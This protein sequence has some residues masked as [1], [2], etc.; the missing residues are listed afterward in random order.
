MIGSEIV[1]SK[2]LTT[3][4]S[5]P[6]GKDGKDCLADSKPAIILG[7]QIVD[8]FCDTYK[9]A[10][11]YLQEYNP[12]DAKGIDWVQ[13]VPFILAMFTQ[14]TV[15]EDAYAQGF[16]KAFGID[17]KKV[18]T[19]RA[20]RTLTVGNIIQVCLMPEGKVPTS[21]EC[22]RLDR[23]LWMTEKQLNNVPSFPLSLIDYFACLYEQH[24]EGDKASALRRQF[25][26]LAK[27]S[28]LSK[29][30]HPERSDLKDCVRLE[31][32]YELMK[33]L[34]SL[35]FVKPSWG[36]ERAVSILDY[37]KQHSLRR[38]AW[39]QDLLKQVKKIG[40]F[41][42]LAKLPCGTDCGLI[43]I[44]G[45]QKNVR[46][47]SLDFAKKLVSAYRASL[48]KQSAAEPSAE[49]VL[50]DLQMWLQDLEKIEPKVP[51]EKVRRK[52]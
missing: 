17:A 27:I 13:N 5:L 4:A 49:L 50:W 26:R 36:I 18:R 33:A 41:R 16:Y 31:S 35:D 19:I 47:M 28:P 39:G 23:V 30:V 48:S 22:A 7:R 24:G 37:A 11:Q 43:S 44:Q 15:I 21:E 9:A 10:S 25:E 20:D 45:I 32:S 42:A 1:L 52:R 14:N 34:A 51:K 46:P 8:Q 12:R 38:D 6:Y 3:A 29:S 2:S 40:V